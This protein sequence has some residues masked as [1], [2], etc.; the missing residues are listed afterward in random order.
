M[1]EELINSYRQIN[2]DVGE[3]TA[4][5]N[6]TEHAWLTSWLGHFIKLSS[7]INII[8]SLSDPSHLGDRSEH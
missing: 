6:K 7:H 8:R 4:A 3:I 2:L 1:I 5:V